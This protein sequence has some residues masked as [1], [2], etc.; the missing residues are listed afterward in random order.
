MAMVEGM[1]LRRVVDPEAVTASWHREWDLFASA[2]LAFILG[3]T[4]P[5]DADGDPADR[6]SG[7]LG[8]GR[9]GDPRRTPQVR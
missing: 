4:R 3:A 8:P 9:T 6:R 1:H 2:A 7:P 5:V